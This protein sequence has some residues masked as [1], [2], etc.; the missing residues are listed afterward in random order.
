MRFE[1]APQPAAVRGRRRRP[2]P[3]AGVVGARDRHGA[4]P[5]RPHPRRDRGQRLRR[6]L[7]ASPGEY[8]QENP[9][10]GPCRLDAGAV[11]VPFARGRSTVTDA[12]QGAAANA[13]RTITRRDRSGRNRSTPRR[14]AS[15]LQR[16]LLSATAGCP[17]ARGGAGRLDN[18]SAMASWARR[19]GR[20]PG[21][22]MEAIPTSFG[23]RPVRGHPKV[24]LEGAHASD[25][26]RRER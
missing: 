8:H 11:V 2:R 1:I 23:T 26:G 6:L 12:S 22:T 10:D 15:P 24:T 16:P 4:H 25:R 5:V 3:A 7:P 14:G 18:I 21:A 17:N 13:L 19:P 9:R 20:N